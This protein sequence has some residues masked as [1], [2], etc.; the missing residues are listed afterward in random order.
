MPLSA[1]YYVLPPP[2]LWFSGTEGA[3]MWH[4]EAYEAYSCT[5][6]FIFFTVRLLPLRTG[7]GDAGGIEEKR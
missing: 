4:R 2:Q 7:G 1:L 3:R 6:D 5:L